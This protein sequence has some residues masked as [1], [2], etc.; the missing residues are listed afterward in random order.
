[1]H[2]F[3]IFRHPAG[4]TVAFRAGWNWFAFFFSVAWLAHKQLWS[5]ALGSA[6]AIAVA[7]FLWTSTVS[8]DV[9]LQH[10][11]Q[12]NIYTSLLLVFLNIITWLSA[13]GTIAWVLVYVPYTAH[14]WRSHHLV[15]SGYQL[16]ATVKAYNSEGAHAVWIMQRE[17]EHAAAEN[18]G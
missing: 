10:S 18:N 11:T 17:A 15:R 3:T 5:R 12:T 4:T 9:A 6:A 8:L 14:K 7:L 1:M 2:T 13:I 16:V